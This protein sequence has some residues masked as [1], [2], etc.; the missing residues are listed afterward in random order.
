MWLYARTISDRQ[1]WLTFDPEETVGEV[2][3]P[4]GTEKGWKGGGWTIYRFFAARLTASTLT[5][6]ISFLIVQN[7]AFGENG[8]MGCGRILLSVSPRF[9]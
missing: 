7:F 1:V 4:G 8:G 2:I 9:C 3:H 6:P 5:F